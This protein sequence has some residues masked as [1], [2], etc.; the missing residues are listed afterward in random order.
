M[1]SGECGLRSPPKLRVPQAWFG[2]KTFL[3]ERDC[4][5]LIKMG[6]FAGFGQGKDF[7]K[8]K[9][10]RHGFVHVLE[11]FFTQNVHMHG[12]FLELS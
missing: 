3:D 8:N 2:G 1:V 6:E 7:V 10:I 5:K 12:K 11:L 4:E 9:E